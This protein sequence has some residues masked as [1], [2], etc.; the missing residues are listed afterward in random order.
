MNPV[1]IGVVLILC[2][3][4]GSIPFGLFMGFIYKVDIRKKGSGNIGAT[5]VLRILGVLPGGIVFALDLLKGTLATLFATFTLGNPT[6][7]VL[8]GAAAILGHMF[9]ICLRF[10]GGR[11]AATGLGVL[12]GITPDLFLIA[13]FLAAVIIAFTRYVSLGSMATAVS[14]AALMFIMKKPLPY[15][16][17]T[18]IVAILIVIRHIPN[19]Q[20][21]ISGKEP[22]IGEKSE[23]S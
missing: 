13:V 18:S 20:R 10:K 5:N 21:L 15:S 22:K 1:L 16:L 2:Y 6:F 17:A 19:I 4:M 9:P 7:T 11:G 14:I 8:G 12:L 3:L 23:Q